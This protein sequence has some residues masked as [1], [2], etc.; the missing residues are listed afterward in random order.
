MD[1][2]GIAEQIEIIKEYKRDSSVKWFF[3]LINPI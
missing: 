2:G 1:T 3:G